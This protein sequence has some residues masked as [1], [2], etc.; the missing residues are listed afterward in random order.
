M[1]Q[2]K[3]S[4]VPIPA[5]W[6]QDAQNMV[7]FLIKR[8]ELLEEENRELRAR[9][10]QNSSNSSR[11]PSQDPPW[12]K[13]GRR[14]RPGGKKPGGQ[15]GHRGKNRPFF[16]REEVSR[17]ES[18]VPEICGGCGK[19]LGINSAVISVHRHQQ[20]EL[21]PIKPIVTEFQVH[22][23]GCSDC[24]HSTQGSIPAEAGNRAAG[25]RLQSLMAFLTCRMRLSRR[26]AKELLEVLLGPGG[27]FSVGCISECEEDLAIALAG[28]Y[29]EALAWLKHSPSVHAD[30]TGWRML[31]DTAWLWVAATEMVSVFRID[32]SR[33]HEAFLALL[34]GFEGI[35]VSD[36]WSAYRKVPIALRQIC[37]AHLKRD[38]QKLVDRKAGAEGQGKWALQELEVIFGLWH[39]F[40]DGEIPKP[41][42]V[43]E[44]MSIKA[45]FARMLKRGT[46][47]SDLKARTFSKNILKAWPAL[48][49]FLH[50]DGRVE[51]TNNR[52]ERALR[53]AVIWRKL[54]FGV[55]SERGRLF[56]ER[57]LTAIGS[58]RQQ[59]REVLDFLTH[60]LVSFRTGAVAPS[61]IPGPSG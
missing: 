1:D 23:L 14:R 10:G 51:P 58:L 15:P 46:Q 20:V 7:K 60:A 43:R 33:G 37:W 25:P 24:G 12:K 32:S 19:H 8:L 30:E 5:T 44:F 13:R 53:P 29:D 27:R 56:V 21:P 26:M 52:A 49:T 54:S 31:G 6:P 3:A 11:P 17:F 50:H 40:L 9:L 57:M 39:A 34:Q 61:L 48:W 38:F 45:R 42:L 28:P 59:G 16:P 47:S 55:Q 36:R 18:V 41:D 4:E 22:T 2:I 35:L